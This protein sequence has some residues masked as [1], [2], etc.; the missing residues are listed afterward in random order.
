MKPEYN[1]DAG[2]CKLDPFITDAPEASGFASTYLGGEGH[3]FCEAIA[4]DEDWNIYVAGNTWSADF[5]ATP[6]AYST[7][8]KGKSDVF[9]AKFDNDLK[10]LLASTLIG[11]DEG[12][13]AYT[14]LYD[15]R[16]FVYV[17]GYTSSENFPTRNRR[18]F[19]S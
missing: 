17:A 3:E 10:T 5:P 8:L 2:A 16:G 7:A 14:M 6:G 19:W 13:C 15:P 1:K 18:P 9:V 12:E 4:L 11:G